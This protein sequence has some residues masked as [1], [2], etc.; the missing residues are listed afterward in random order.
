MTRRGAREVADLLG[1]PLLRSDPEARVAPFYV[2]AV[3]YGGR[4]RN[5][6]TGQ[7]VDFLRPDDRH[8]AALRET[9]ARW[10]SAAPR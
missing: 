1:V 5:R 7:S 9:L 6:A 4:L 3:D 2:S 8:L 10:R